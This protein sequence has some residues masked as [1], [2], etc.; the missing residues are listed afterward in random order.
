MESLQYTPKESIPAS[1][2]EIR[3]YREQIIKNLKPGALPTELDI[4]LSET[5]IRKMNRNI[6]Y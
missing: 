6:K 5:V 1:L 2:P 3:G 4:A